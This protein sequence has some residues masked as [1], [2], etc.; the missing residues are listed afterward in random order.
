MGEGK[1]YLSIVVVSRN[2]DHG[3]NPLFRTQLCINS[4]Y[5]QCNRFQLPVELI[6]VDW[7][8]PLDRPGLADVIR[9]PSDRRFI[10]TRVITVP[11]QC[12]RS[13]QHSEKIPLFQMIGKNVGIRRA[14]G[15]FVL[16]T[17]IDILFSDELMEFI[18]GRNLR[19]G[20]SYRADRFDVRN[21]VLQEPLQNILPYAR[22]HV[23][24]VNIKPGTFFNVAMGKKGELFNPFFN[25]IVQINQTRL[26]LFALKL[27]KIIVESTQYILLKILTAF[28]SGISSVRISIRNLS[29]KIQTTFFKITLGSFFVNMACSLRSAVFNSKKFIGAVITSLRDLLNK[30]ANMLHLRSSHSIKK[31]N[32]LIN[33]FTLFAYRFIINAEFG[34]PYVHLNG[35]GDFTLFAKED[36]DA[37]GGYFEEP[38]FSWNVDSLILIDAYYS[39]F[40]EVYLMPPRNTFHVEHS[41]G[42][43]WTPGK[44]E[45]LLFE[46]LDKSGIPYIRWEDCL[47]YARQWREE[48]NKIG[49]LNRI[50][51]MDYGFPE[52]DLPERCIE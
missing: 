44:G 40:P 19:P 39:G 16:A 50:K 15:E 6:I 34:Y 32:G 51:K 46:R 22:D 42:S 13:L 45:Q 11:W 7:N 5:E 30:T 48:K 41:A 25:A 14:H 9:W 47:S 24:R 43:G 37:L 12:H 27:F 31:E 4:L 52:W 2:D 10:R 20:F 23:I 18:A 29:L 3:G 35:C 38:I 26:I 49:Y 33:L 21:E 1:P 8:P 36:W 28:S 17:N